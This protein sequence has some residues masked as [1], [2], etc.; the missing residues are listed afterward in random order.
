MSVGRV[1]GCGQ[2]GAVP[3]KVLAQD[4]K[5]QRTDVGDTGYDAGNSG[6][7]TPQIR[8]FSGTLNLTP[9]GLS[10]LICNIEDIPTL[11]SCCAGRKIA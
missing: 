9:L 8:C 6:F 1:W 10:C 5:C 3:Q 2:T 11:Q 7:E 4:K